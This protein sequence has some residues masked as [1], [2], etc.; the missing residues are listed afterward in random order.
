MTKIIKENQDFI[1][2][3]TDPAEA[4]QINNNLLDQK[5]KVDLLE[6]FTQE[7]QTTITY[8]LNTIPLTAKDKLLAGADPDYI[9][10]YDRINDFFHSKTSLVD[11]RYIVFC[12]MCE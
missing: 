12:D 11:G 5:Y 7:G 6:G 9:T 3:T 8:Y 4:M 10:V 2:Y 1:C